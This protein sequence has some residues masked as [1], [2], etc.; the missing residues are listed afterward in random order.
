MLRF[1]LVCAVVP[2]VL[3]TPLFAKQGRR[4]EPRVGDP[5]PIELVKAETASELRHRDG[6]ISF[7]RSSAIKPRRLLMQGDASL[8]ERVI[9]LMAVGCSGGRSDLP[10]LVTILDGRLPV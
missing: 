4:P 3:A 10:K 7:L 9:A 6:R 8:E 1:L 5:E 2:A